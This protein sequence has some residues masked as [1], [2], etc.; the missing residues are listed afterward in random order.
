MRIKWSLFLIFVI[1]V[2]FPLTAQEQPVKADEIWMDI[3]AYAVGPDD[4]NP[5]LWNS[6]LW[7]TEVYPYP[8]KTDI[9]RRRQTEKHRVIVLENRYTRVLILPDKGGKILAAIDKTNNDFDFIYFNRVIKPGLISLAGAWLSGGIEWNFP[10][11]G[12][13]A[14][15]FSTVNRAIQ[16][17]PDGSATVFVGTEEWVRRMKWVIAITLFPD[18]SYVKTAVRL[19]NGTFTHNHGYF[20]ADAATHA[21]NDTRIVFP[22]G[23]STF[24]FKR[25]NPDPWPVYGGVDLSWYKNTG[26]LGR[27]FQRHS[28][29]FQRRVQLRKGERHRPFRR[30]L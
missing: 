3:P 7:N 5:P 24:T 14:H 18:R 6:P 27:P 2:S 29:R 30:P 19:Y 25:R 22:P 23:D 16:R 1:L 13:T 17:N 4:P 15:A 28:R 20:W 10:T 26:T 11:Y 12:H 9:T 8:M 21:W